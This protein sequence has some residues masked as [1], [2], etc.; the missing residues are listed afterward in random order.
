MASLFKYVT[1]WKM[2]TTYVQYDSFF[3]KNKYKYTYRSKDVYQII[4]I[5]CSS[6]K[7]TMYCFN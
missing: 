1:Y 6:A 3:K 7:K 4:L 2:I 5:F